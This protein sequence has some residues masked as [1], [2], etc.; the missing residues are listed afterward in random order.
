MAIYRE[1]KFTHDLATTQLFPILNP[2]QTSDNAGWRVFKWIFGT[3]ILLGAVLIGITLLRVLSGEVMPDS[4]SQWEFA[5]GGRF[6]IFE[7]TVADRLTIESNR[8]IHKMPG[9]KDLSSWDYSHGGWI[10]FEMETSNQVVSK[11][12]LKMKSEGLILVVG[13]TNYSGELEEFGQELH[14]R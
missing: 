13:A 6:E 3:G 12:M 5:G 10:D 4:E 8:M 9:T 11:G 1:L 14:S 2:D 7:A